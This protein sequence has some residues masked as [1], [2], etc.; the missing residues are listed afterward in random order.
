MSGVK[1]SSAN[2]DGVYIPKIDISNDAI[3]KTGNYNGK[4][5]SPSFT[6]HIIEVLFHTDKYSPSI[7]HK[8]KPFTVH[9]FPSV[10]AARDCIRIFTGGIF[11]SLRIG[12]IHPSRV[13]G[14]V[15]NFRVIVASEY[16][17]VRFL[18]SIHYDKGCD[19]Y[20]IK[21]RIVAHPLHIHL[22]F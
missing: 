1:L 16:S 15:T 22:K 20:F 21:F 12:E 6:S 7:Y 8:E 5:D 14:E 19:H 18:Y 10:E 3:Y 11:F 4:C 2:S 17:P 9:H 13:Y